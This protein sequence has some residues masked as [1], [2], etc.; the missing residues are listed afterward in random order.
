MFESS[1]I[2]LSAQKDNGQDRIQI[3]RDGDKLII[4]IADGAGGRSGGAEAAEM[5]TN[6]MSQRAWAL[7]SQKDCENL[8]TEIDLKIS[9]D[10]V[11][12]ETT[13][14]IVVVSPKG[15]FGASVGDSGAWILSGTNID[16]LTQ[17][18]IRKPCLGTGGAS[19]VGFFR[20]ALKGTLLVATDG[21][22]KYTSREMIAGVICERSLSDATVALVQ[23]VRYSSG[24][25]PDDVTIGLCRTI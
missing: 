22:L 7:A 14:I 6:L 17:N 20:S 11:A 25:L 4:A 12:G 8:L 16:N 19:A 18:Q 21:L 13:A 23:L 24:N 9:D 2:A 1:H 10:K 15:V 5:A 3:L